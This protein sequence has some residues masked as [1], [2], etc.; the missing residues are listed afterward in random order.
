MLELDRG[1]HDE[2]SVSD[3]ESPMIVTKK[4]LPRRTVLR[5]LGATIALPFLDPMLPALTAQTKAA[6]RLHFLYF[7]MGATIV[8]PGGMKQYPKM[9]PSMDNWTPPVDGPLTQLSPILQPLAPFKD[10]MIVLTNLELDPANGETSANHASSN[11]AYLSCATQ[12]ATEGNDYYLGTTVDQIAAKEIGRDTLLPSLEL[13]TDLLAQVGVCDNGV[14]C[15]YMNSLSWSS[16]TTPLPIEAD[17]RAVFERMFGEGGTAEERASEARKNRS[18]LDS[19]LDDMRRLERQIGVGGRKQLSQYLDTI[20]EV[21]QRIQ[22]AEAL[23][24]KADAMPDPERPM[25]VPASWEDHVKLMFDLQVL[26]FQTDV[27][28]VI[29]FQL[30]REASSRT[31]PQIGVPDSHHPVTHHRWVPEQLAKMV[32]INT[33]HASLYAHFLE[34]LRSTPDGDGSLLDHGIFVYG[35]GMGNSDAHDHMNLPALVVGGASGRL[36]GGR[37]IRYAERTPMANLYL[38]L[39]DK[40]GVQLEKFGDSTGKLPELAAP[41]SL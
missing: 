39:L 15:A 14:S 16:P 36:R 26:A 9:H 31:Y 32:K 4:A 34:K 11:S 41:L 37:H 7:P 30:A 38:S 20:R 33:Y 21:E 18:I 25:G 3:E 23:A 28:R 2:R 6:T 35:S 29:S 19:V 10:Q 27:T 12:K 22:K 17:P 13:G 5:G 1:D 24:A 8:P 40:V